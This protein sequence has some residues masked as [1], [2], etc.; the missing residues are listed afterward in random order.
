M[1]ST[2]SGGSQY[3]EIYSS[4]HPQLV[5]WFRGVIFVVPLSC[6][7]ETRGVDSV[8]CV[9][10]ALNLSLLKH[11]KP[12]QHVLGEKTQQLAQL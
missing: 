8:T 1:G 4:Q 2:T 6:G 3:F 9:L 5:S 10:D 12:F 7:V 11:N